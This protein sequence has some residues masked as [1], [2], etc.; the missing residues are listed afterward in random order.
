MEEQ[1]KKLQKEVQAALNYMVTLVL[2]EEKTS[3]AG[4]HRKV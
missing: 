1:L 2:R 4:I 3:V